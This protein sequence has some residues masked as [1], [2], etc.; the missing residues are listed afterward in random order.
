MTDLF[1][2]LDFETYWQHGTG[3]LGEGDVDLMADR[4][5][6][7]LPVLRGRHVQGI[8]RDASIRLEAWRSPPIQN[9]TDILFGTSNKSPTGPSKPGCLDISDFRLPESLSFQKAAL[10]YRLASTRIDQSTGTAMDQSLRAVEVAAPCPL[11]GM[12]RWT[13]QRRLVLCPD[14]ASMV[15]DARDYW[16]THLTDCLIEARAFGS[17]RT[18]G[19]GRTLFDPQRH[20]IRLDRQEKTT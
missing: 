9:M 14:E 4:D 13:P 6:H 1:V 17:K 5:V 3:A 12:I 18:R 11:G 2:I 8:L 10:F 19:F 16:I 7:G 20:L 15:E